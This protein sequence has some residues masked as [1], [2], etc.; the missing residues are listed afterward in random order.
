M[1]FTDTS[2]TR[3]ASVKTL[4]NGLFDYAGLFPPASLPLPEA[5]DEY[6][7]HRAEPDAWMLGPFV[8]PVSRLAELE[9]IA[10]RIPDGSP[11]PLQL[12]PP[13][14]PDAA[15][16][17]SHLAQSLDTVSDFLA[18]TALSVD[19]AGFEWRIP[20]DGVQDAEAAMAAVT[21][22]ESAFRTSAFASVPRHLEIHRTDAFTEQVPFF[23]MALAAQGNPALLRAKIRCGG[24]QAGD[25]PST[26]ELAAF[27]HAAIRTAHP[28]KATAGLHH[29]M[30]HFHAGQQVW[31]HGFLNVFFA[32]TI[33]RAHGLHVDGIQ[34]ILEDTDAGHFHFTEHGIA[35]YDLSATVTEF[36]RDRR[37]LSLS[38][39]SC[40]FDEPRQDLRD[41]GWLTH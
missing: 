13:P 12:L 20:E 10:D 18:R 6:L 1:P 4:L 26:A 19:V 29:P 5:M 30:R 34:A 15:A 8:L 2:F 17:A 32:T 35:W 23:F 3:F 36:I 9:A 27:L 40:S 22:V 28:F 31:M 38:I 33:G 16:A 41:L 14:A 24:M 11:V 39:G 21:A 7:V 37:T 25:F